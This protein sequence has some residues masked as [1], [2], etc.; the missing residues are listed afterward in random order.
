MKSVM[1][2]A[3]GLINFWKSFG[4]DILFSYD[5]PV[6]AAT[7]H[8]SCFFGVLQEKPLGIA[9]I[10]PSR[11]KSDGRYGESPNRFFT[12]HQFQVVLNP[13]PKNIRELYFQS[14]QSIG[15]D[16]SKHDFK[17]VENNWE[18][19]SLGAIGVGWEVWCDVMEITQW[20][21]F[22]KIGDEDLSNTPVELA[23]GLE[24]IALIALNKSTIQE[25]QWSTNFTY[26]EMFYRREY[27]FSKYCLETCEV[28][29]EEF[30]KLAKR[31]EKTVLQDKLALPAYELLLLM[32]DIFNSLDALGK[33]DHVS[34]KEYIDKM[35]Y[36]ANMIVKTYRNQII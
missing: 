23:Y 32:N 27:E 1:D 34:R 11:R 9:Y 15:I 13:C 17:F 12:H 19:I 2:V 30:F 18:N 21:Y 24:R 6:G 4:C 3:E 26:D 28:E 5:F 8:P 33:I 14:L 20:T 7:F 36:I 25:C 35:R 31:A 10:Q 22:Q 29:K 16:L